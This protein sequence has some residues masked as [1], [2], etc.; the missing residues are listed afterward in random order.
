MLW[1]GTRSNPLTL[2]AAKD[3]YQSAVTT[4]KIGK[5]T[6]VTTDFTLKKQ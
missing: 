3:G 6:N 1:L 5:G 4:V 2:I